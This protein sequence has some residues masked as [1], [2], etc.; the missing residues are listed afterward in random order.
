MRLIVFCRK[1]VE[2]EYKWMVESLHNV[3]NGLEL[4]AMG[5]V[6]S[7]FTQVLDIKKTLKGYS[8]AAG[9]H[10]NYK[11]VTLTISNCYQQA[12]VQLEC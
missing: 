10:C 6:L 2:F 11:L 9:N 4:H 12:V 5:P 8:Q 3:H 7:I 1:A